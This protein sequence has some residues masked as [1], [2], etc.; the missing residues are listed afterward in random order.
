[1]KKIRIIDVAD[2]AGVSKSTVSQYL[3]GRFS[4]MSPDTKNRIKSAIE[5]LNYV[6]NPIARSLKT[7][8]TDTIGVIVRD[9]MG[10]DTSRTIR[11]IDDF[12]KERN[13]NVLIYSTDFD[14]AVE[15]RSLKIL[16]QMRVDGIII[17]STG[18]NNPLI[19]AEVKSGFPIVQIQLE[20]D[21]LK[22]SVVISDY[23]AGG[24]LGTEYLVKHGH[25]RICLLTQ[26][27]EAFRSRYE[28][29]LGYKEALEKYK[30]PFSQDMV[31]IWDREKGF[32]NSIEEILSQPDPPTAFFTMHLAITAEL[33]RSLN[34]LGKRIPEDV[35][36][37]GFDEIPMVEF[38]KVPISVVRQSPYEIGKESAKLLLE[39][40]SDKEMGTKKIILPCTLEKR[41]S[42]ADLEV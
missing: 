28:R 27:S 38:F 9:I 26:E 35:S 7:D 42:C 40:I 13:Y 5:E 1:M 36:V 10:F 8:R 4:Y 19:A 18:K 2:Q 37:L 15:E 14:P 3:N 32:A 16:M 22:T 21:E 11:G 41:G 33:L 23:K 30:I 12:C 17:A 39:K 6:P 25:K 20:Y 24:F 29:Y 34:K 31:Q